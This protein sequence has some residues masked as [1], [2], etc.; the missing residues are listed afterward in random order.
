VEGA[1][2]DAGV[3]AGGLEGVGERV[4]GSGAW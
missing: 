1:A 3:A 4:H 2:E